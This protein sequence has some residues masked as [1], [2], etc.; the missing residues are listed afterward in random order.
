M[1]GRINGASKW[2]IGLVAVAVAILVPTIGWINAL[3]Q[4][5]QVVAGLTKRTEAL[6]G[7]V[8]K[9]TGDIR[10]TNA[11]GRAHQDEILRVL[12]RIET[13]QMAQ[14]KDIQKLAVDVARLQP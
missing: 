1:A 12:K 6:E 5:T 11:S 7:K 9:N 13:E 10:E 3:G 2:L 14:R 8:D 4:Q